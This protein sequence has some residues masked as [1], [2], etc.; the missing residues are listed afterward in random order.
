VV[1]YMKE[2]C[3]LCE[4]V[5]EKLEELNPTGSVRISTRDITQDQELCERY[6]NLIPVVAVNGKVKLAG[7]IL[8]D[9]STL[10]DVLRKTV[11]S[12]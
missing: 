12:V 9:P 11:F 8:A 3:H 5:I 6:K 4:R 2:N 10:E 7:A 1:V